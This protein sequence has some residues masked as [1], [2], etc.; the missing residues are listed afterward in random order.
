[1][2][3]GGFC[4]FSHAGIQPRNAVRAVFKRILI[5]CVGNICRS[6]AAEYLFRHHLARRGIEFS[7]AGLGALVG[8]SMDDTALQLLQEQ[9]VDGTAHRARQLAPA[10]LHEA[11]LVLVME[12][13]HATAVARLAPEASGKVFLLDKWLRARNI[14]D[15]YQQQRPAFEHVHMMIDQGV[16]SWLPYL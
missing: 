3:V 12:K 13:S 9:G 2:A 7:S 16:R 14:P 4:G 1:M 15:P 11:D 6:P 10:M 5:V 8:C